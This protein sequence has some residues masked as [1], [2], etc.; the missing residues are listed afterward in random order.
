[1]FHTE[2]AN[3]INA[4]PI[5]IT[6]TAPTDIPSIQLIS[7]HSNRKQEI[8]LVVLR[9]PQLVTKTFLQKIFEL[10]LSYTA[11]AFLVTDISTM[12]PE[13]RQDHF[14]H[15]FGG[16][17]NVFLLGCLN[18]SIIE[19]YAHANFHTYSIPR[20]GKAIYLSGVACDPQQQGRGFATTILTQAVKI[21]R[22]EEGVKYLTMRTMNH[23]VV[24]MCKRSCATE[25]AD[26]EEPDP[27]QKQVKVYPVDEI[28]QGR[29]D[30][31]LVCNTL[32]TE[33]KWNQGVVP[34]RLIIERAYPD[35]LIP[36]FRGHINM[37]KVDLVRDRVDE[38]ID[39]DRGDAMCLV[40]DM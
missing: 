12:S 39:R 9:N 27:E 31:I 21:L 7:T 40:I 5:S 24:K 11:R 16:G 8:S 34:E 13:D 18:E 32:A 3:L 29:E 35:F 10:T 38:I 23:N 14:N 26:G 1:M 30:L 6:Q 4:E 15:T 33:L 20:C 2:L 17:G 22:Q 28:E 19:L 36:I 25:I 37:D